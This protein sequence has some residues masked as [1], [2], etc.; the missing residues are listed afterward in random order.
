[1]CI[2]CCQ[3]EDVVCSDH[4]AEVA[5]SP[6]IWPRS[7]LLKRADARRTALNE[8]APSIMTLDEFLTRYEREPLP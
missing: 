3:S 7:L 4:E 8:S 5:E 6:D 1:M 2:D